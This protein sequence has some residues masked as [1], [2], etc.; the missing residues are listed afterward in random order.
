MSRRKQANP[1][2]RFPV[3]DDEEVLQGEEKQQKLEEQPSSST[4]PPPPPSNKSNGLKTSANPLSMLEDS[5]RKFDP[6]LFAAFNNGSA[7]P[8]QLSNFPFGFPPN[9]NGLNALYKV[10]GNVPDPATKPANRDGFRPEMSSPVTAPKLV[11]PVE[12]LKKSKVKNSAIS[13]NE[14]GRFMEETMKTVSPAQ[15]F[16]MQQQMGAYNMMMNEELLK[17]FALLSKG[18]K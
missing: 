6:R 17:S 10:V 2:R 8:S 9:S 18:R 1:K 11:P 3:D 12:E 4:P 5:M 14:M 7:L 15:Q 16:W 13:A